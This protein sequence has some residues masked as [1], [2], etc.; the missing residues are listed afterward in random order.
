MA[1][2]FFMDVGKNFYLAFDSSEIFR[3]YHSLDPSFEQI[4]NE[5]KDLRLLFDKGNGLKSTPVAVLLN[6]GFSFIVKDAFLSKNEEDIK[7][8]PLSHTLFED[9]KAWARAVLKEDE[10]ISF[11]VNIKE[12]KELLNG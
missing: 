8:Y 5:A 2:Y 3:I 4:K 1:K 10:G 9:N 7:I 12:L 6:D 11:L